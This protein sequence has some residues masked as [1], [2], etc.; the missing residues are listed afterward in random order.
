MKQ[1][2][3][4]RPSDY[5][6]SLNIN[7]LEGRMLKIK[8][9]KLKETEIL[10]VY[11]HHSTL[12]RWWGLIQVLTNYG[13]VTVPDLP[14]FGG[15]DSFYKISKKPTID[16][17]ADY[18]ATFITLQYQKKKIVIVGLSFGFV[19]V[20]RM[21]QRHP[22]LTSKVTLLISIVGFAHKDDFIFSKTRYYSYLLTSRFF[23]NYIFSKFFRYVILSSPVIRLAY[24]KTYNAKHKFAGIEDVIIHNQIIDFE[25]ELWHSNDLR[26]WMYTTNEFLK[27]DNCKIRVKLPVWHVMVS[28]DNYFNNSLVEQHMRIIFSNYNGVTSNAENHAPSIIA[29]EHMAQYMV[30]LKLKRILSKLE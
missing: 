15:M 7:G 8:A 11:G 14:G 3:S 6:S 21:L 5:I 26:T 16:N 23:S 27:L 24:A 25:I 9:K 18:L 13:N 10:F 28:K 17:Y 20:T 12:E 4:P 22:N 30:P 1:K 19:V 2:K 29:D